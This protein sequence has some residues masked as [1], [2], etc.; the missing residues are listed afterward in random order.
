MKCTAIIGLAVMSLTGMQA[1]PSLTT[2]DLSACIDKALAYSYSLKQS[3][4]NLRASHGD[5]QASMG[6][7][8]PQVNLGAGNGWNAGLVVDPVTNQIQTNTLGTASGSLGMSLNVFDGGQNLNR[9]RQAKVNAAVAMLQVDNAAQLVVLNTASQYL[10]LLVAIEAERIAIGQETLSEKQLQRTQ[11]M[12]DAGAISL[13]ELLQAKSQL[14]RDIQRVVAAMAQRSLAHLSLSQTMGMTEDFSIDGTLL[15]INDKPTA[16]LAI[17]PTVLY[18]ASNGKQ[19][20]IQMA[21]LQVQSSDLAVKVA[22]AAR[23]PRLSMSGQMSTSYSD[24][25]LKQTGSTSAVG[26]IGY[27]ISPQGNQIP[28]MTTYQ[29]PTF[30]AVNLQDQFNNNRR[31]YVG[32]NLSIP[33]FSGFQIANSIQRAQVQHDNAALQLMQEEDSYRQVIERAH[34]DAQSAWKNH[35]A[36]K[37]ALVAAKRSLDDAQ[38]RREEGIMNALDYARI[39]D[40]YY[41]A[42]SEA[43]RSKYD[44]IFKNYILTFYANPPQYHAEDQR[45]F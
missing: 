37:A 3:N 26:E 19:P 7:M 9:W 31:Q 38:I 33:V 5:V 25:A 4:N 18:A 11:T 6:S 41:A 32:F 35:E 40:S 23:L 1:Q 29:I 22:K 17:Q 14:A 20:S 44:A 8:L 28:V 24:R 43:I 36:A 10:T 21:T 45:Q 42:S 27:F 2:L 12:H 15:G 13:S 16:E 34:H 39:Q 30:T